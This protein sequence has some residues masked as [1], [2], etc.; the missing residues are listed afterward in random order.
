MTHR[1]HQHRSPCTFEEAT[2][3]GA[4][5]VKMDQDGSATH[6][7]VN[8]SERSLQRSDLLYEE[9]VWGREIRFRIEFDARASGLHDV[10]DC[11]K[12]SMV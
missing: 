9:K 3:L 7:R 12:S 11:R 5:V 10:G 1:T 6:T 4:D 2:E 8:R